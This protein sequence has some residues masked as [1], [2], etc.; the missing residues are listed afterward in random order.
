MMFTVAGAGFRGVVA[1]LR[2]APT[3][4]QQAARRRAV[5][6]SARRLPEPLVRLAAIAEPLR[7]AIHPVE[8]FQRRGAAALGAAAAHVEREKARR[9]A[10]EQERRRRAALLDGQPRPKGGKL[11]MLAAASLAVRALRQL[12]RQQAAMMER[13]E[14]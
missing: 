13:K 3:P 4:A 8:S 14:Q 5:R 12:K 6:D 9:T 11:I 1:G 10:R 7:S 2:A